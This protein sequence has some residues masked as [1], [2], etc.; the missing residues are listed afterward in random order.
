LNVVLAKMLYKLLKSNF[1]T[2][3]DGGDGNDGKVINLAG[4]MTTPI[5]LKLCGWMDQVIPQ[6]L[7]FCR[8]KFVRIF[9]SSGSCT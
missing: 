8:G 1:Y 5:K 9:I 4:H 3:A 2:D 7:W 6:L